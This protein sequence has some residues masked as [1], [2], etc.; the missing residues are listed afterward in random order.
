MKTLHLDYETRSVLDLKEV[1][2]HNY[3]KHASTDL[4]CAAY[5][6]GS[7]PDLWLP[8]QPC[9]P[10]IV[11]HVKAGGAIAAW[12]AP[13]EMELWR[14]VAAPKYGWPAPK[15]EQFHCSM[16]AAYA[17]GLPGALEDAALALGL[18]VLKDTEGRSLML[19]MSRPRSKPGEPLRWWDELEK[20][21][22]LAA[23]CQQDA[24]V[25]MV[26]GERLLPLSNSERR[27]WL[28]DYAINQRGVK[29]DQPSAKAAITLVEKVKERCNA[30]LGRITGGAVQSA[31]ALPALKE[32]LAGKGVPVEGLA[33]QDVADLLAGNLP[34]ECRAALVLRQEAG[35]AS[36]AKL[37]PMVAKAGAD[38][39]L[40][41]LLQYHGAAT[42][43]WAGRGVQVHNLIRD[44]PDA[45]VVERILALVRAGQIEA[46]DM[47]YGPPMGVVSRCLRGFFIPGEG[48]VLIAGDYNAIESRGC[49]WFSGE[50]WK[51]KAFEEIDRGASY[52]IYEMTAGKILGRPPSEIKGRDRQV[53]GKTPELAFQY[54]GGV[55]AWRA[56]D[57]QLPEEEVRKVLAGWREQHPRV[58]AT[59]YALE[60]AAVNAVRTPGEVFTAGHPGR[61]VKYKKVGS[62]LWCLLP[63]GRALCYPYP[64]L[65]EGEYGPQLTY[66]KVPA[67]DAKDKGK[68]VDDPKNSSNWARVKTYGGSLM[69]NVI[70]AICRDILAEAMLSMHDKGAAIVLHIHDEIVLEVAREKADGARRAMQEIMTT[71]PA[72]AKGFPL[73]A[74]PSV[75][76]RYGK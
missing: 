26:A 54:G 10:A 76:W 46:I 50:S 62:F 29:V 58:K 74:K 28:M 34:D 68:L 56:F 33:K 25:E 22:R 12:N 6:F 39:R 52:G 27:V 57:K 38:G 20:L 42:G 36:T 60:K 21:K 55:G 24:R 19:R 3:A 65:L 70:Q 18:P 15:A 32:W 61:Q 30:E 17:M 45:E 53:F 41:G 66:F 49:A 67:Q 4:W 75:M 40:H 5:S 69:E 51:V 35:K 16:A 11:E 13:F 44:V 8:G 2:L 14:E 9:P 31:T 1:G 59:W 37:T 72:W 7:D 73:A 64:K 63:S 43:R 47:I 23:Y 48:N 71:P